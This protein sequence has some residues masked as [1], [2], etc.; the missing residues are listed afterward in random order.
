MTKYKI[1][2]KTTISSLEYVVNQALENGWILVG[3]VSHTNGNSTTNSYHLHEGYSQAMIKQ[4][5]NGD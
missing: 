5:D 4:E 3:G 1:F 2:E